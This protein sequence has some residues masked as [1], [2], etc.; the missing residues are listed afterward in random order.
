[1]P[2]TSQILEIPACMPTSLEIGKRWLLRD[3]L[4]FVTCHLDVTYSAEIEARLHT[5]QKFEIKKGKPQSLSSRLW[6]DSIRQLEDSST[7]THYAEPACPL[8]GNWKTD[9][10]SPMS[11]HGALKNGS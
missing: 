6:G 8:A 9:E 5:S 7:Y 4:S 3:H 10:K 11:K 1:M 2:L